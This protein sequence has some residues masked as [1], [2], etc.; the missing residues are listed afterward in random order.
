MRRKEWGRKEGIVRV[1]FRTPR[2]KKKACPRIARPDSK[3]FLIFRL[4]SPG[5]K[6]K[7]GKRENKHNLLLIP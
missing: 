1:V 7:E 3:F 5:V 2:R 4:E 6:K